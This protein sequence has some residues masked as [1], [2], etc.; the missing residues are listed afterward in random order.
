MGSEGELMNRSGQADG[1]EHGVKQAE[2]TTCS[3]VQSALRD[4][5]ESGDVEAVRMA[6]EGGAS[7]HLANAHGMQPIHFAIHYVYVC[8]HDHCTVVQ[9]LVK[10]GASVNAS[11]NN[12]LQPIHYASSN[13]HT[14]MVRCLV[15]L[16]GVVDACDSHGMQPI[17]EASRMGQIAAVQCLVELGAVADTTALQL[18]MPEYDEVDHALPTRIAWCT[19][20]NLFA[21]NNTDAHFLPQF[22]CWTHSFCTQRHPPCHLLHTLRH[23]L[24]PPVQLH[25]MMHQLHL[26]VVRVASTVCHTACEW[27]PCSGIHTSG[28]VLLSSVRYSALVPL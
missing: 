22:S 11:D 10:Y 16:G 24:K 2:G 6:L 3:D 26:S 27:T 5:C 8:T 25:V 15:E 19:T 28:L 17:H 14:A 20:Y 4:G 9:L 12:G 21:R 1:M 13:G 7:V 18:A 23:C